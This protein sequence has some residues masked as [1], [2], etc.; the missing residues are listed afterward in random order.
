MRRLTEG[1]AYSK[2]KGFR[3][4]FFLYKIISKYLH[5]CPHL[6]P[7]QDR[8]ADL[9]FIYFQYRIHSPGMDQPEVLRGSIIV[10]V[11]VLDFG[12]ITVYF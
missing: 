11:A 7:H 2:T 10:F 9:A 4:K 1:T 8:V 5:P 6:Y 3:Q 12:R